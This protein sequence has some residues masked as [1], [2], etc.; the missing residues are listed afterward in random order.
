MEIQDKKH[1]EELKDML[2]HEK[3][4]REKLQRKQEKMDILQVSIVREKKT[5]FKGF[6]L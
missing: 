1:K 6:S 2:I 5:I 3:L 4:V